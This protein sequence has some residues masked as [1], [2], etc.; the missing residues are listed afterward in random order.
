MAATSYYKQLARKRTA[1]ITTNDSASFDSEKSPVDCQDGCSCIPRSAARLL[2]VTCTLPVPRDLNTALWV[3]NYLLILG[4]LWL[5][6]NTRY[7]FTTYGFETIAYSGFW[8]TIPV[9][10]QTAE[11]YVLSLNTRLYTCGTLKFRM[12]QLGCT[13]LFT[14][15]HKGNVHTTLSTLINVCRQ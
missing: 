1:I 8:P 15:L 9:H 11:W 12:Y 5:W 10:H 4:V 2:Q 13:R 3:V 7:A 6:R 14:P